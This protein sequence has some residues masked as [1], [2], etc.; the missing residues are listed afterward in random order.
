[1]SQQ[2]HTT[3][4][5]DTTDTTLTHC[6]DVTCIQQ[7]CGI[8][9]DEAVEQYNKCRGDVVLAISSYFDATVVAT[10]VATTTT[11]TG[12]T[13]ATQQ[14]LHALREIA[15]EKDVLLNRILHKPKQAPKQQNTVMM[16]NAHNDNNDNNDSNDSNSVH[17]EELEELDDA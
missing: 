2:P 15:N 9:L 17:I 12:E 8:S 5:T 6:D 1:M 3:D 4:T 14:A 11:G 10:V 16:S 7:Q 13:D